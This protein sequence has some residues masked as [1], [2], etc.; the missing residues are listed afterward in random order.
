MRPNRFSADDLLNDNLTTMLSSNIYYT[1]RSIVGIN[2]RN[3]KISNE[4]VY[5]IDENEHLLVRSI[6]AFRCRAVLSL[7]CR[8][9]RMCTVFDENESY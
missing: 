9:R 8:R 7:I 2:S 3:R 5:C 4:S 6:Q 1:C